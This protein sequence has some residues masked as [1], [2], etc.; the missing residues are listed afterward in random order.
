MWGSCRWQI[1]LPF[2]TA[3]IIIKCI[4]LMEDCNSEWIMCLW[5]TC[6]LNYIYAVGKKIIDPLLILYVCPLTKKLS[7]YNFNGRF[8]NKLICILMSEIR[9]W[10]PIIQ[11]NIWLPSVFYTCIKDP[12]PQKQSINQSD[13]KLSTMVKT[14][15]L[16][17]D[18]RDCRP[19]QGWNGLQDHR[20]EAWWESDN[21]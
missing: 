12:C 8:S 9:I 20:Q 7:I 21:S 18:V 6:E 2:H 15:E 17:K 10:I 13:S 11:Q 4:I 1:V 14:K 19:T 5:N 16:S 3:A